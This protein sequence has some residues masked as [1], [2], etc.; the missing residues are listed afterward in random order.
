[1]NQTSFISISATLF[2]AS[3]FFEYFIK[4]N[5]GHED[6]IDIIPF[7]ALT[8]SLNLNVIYTDVTF[9]KIIIFVT[10]LFKG[11][12]SLSPKK[13][14][15]DVLLLSSGII[16]TSLLFFV[17]MKISIPLLT[18]NI[19][20]I[21]ITT[22]LMLIKAVT[23]NQ[24]KTKLNKESLEIHFL[25]FLGFVA[26]SIGNSPYNVNLGLLIIIL[27]QLSDLFIRLKY[28]YVDV[29]KVRSKRCI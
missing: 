12:L 27:F 6:I 16:I 2:F 19:A 3:F 21:L 10:L 26:I 28:Y 22:T 7:A 15:G 5:D 13:I 29:N 9:Y 8:L 17:T 23:Y 4:K 1:M 14:S 20:L 11:L 24:S 25:A 18:I